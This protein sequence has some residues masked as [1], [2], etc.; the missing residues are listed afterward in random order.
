MKRSNN[1]CRNCAGYLGCNSQ[2]KARGMPC[3]DYRRGGKKNEK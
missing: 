1:T 3:I 2:D